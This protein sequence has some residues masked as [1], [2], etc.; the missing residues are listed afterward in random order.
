MGCV[1]VVRDC[2]GLDSV[3]SEVGSC[4]RCR[5]GSFLYHLGGVSCCVYVLDFIT[6]RDMCVHVPLIHERPLGGCVE[7]VGSTM[8]VFCFVQVLVLLLGYEFIVLFFLDGGVFV[9][10]FMFYWWCLLF[11]CDG[12]SVCNCLV[13]WYDCGPDCFGFVGRW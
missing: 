1:G 7:V 11:L 8:L 2:W 4:E 12:M 5:C 3:V 9:V 6:I 13:C 10:R